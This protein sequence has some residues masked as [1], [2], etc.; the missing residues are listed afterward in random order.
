MIDL[1]ETDV[2]FSQYSNALQS[3]VVFCVK[4]ICSIPAPE[5]AYRPIDKGVPSMVLSDFN[6]A[7]ALSFMSFPSML[8]VV[9]GSPLIMRFPL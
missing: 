2:R 7:K 5:K 6:P 4:L 3:H 1:I 9:S 8:T